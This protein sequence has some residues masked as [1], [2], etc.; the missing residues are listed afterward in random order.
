MTEKSYLT[1]NPYDIL[2]PVENALFKYNN[3]SESFKLFG[4]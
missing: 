3:Y 4:N 2:N 1:N